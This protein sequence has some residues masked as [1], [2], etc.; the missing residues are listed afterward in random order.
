MSD[1]QAVNGFV[2]VDESCKAQGPRGQQQ[3]AIV[4][5]KWKNNVSYKLYPNVIYYVDCA[6]HLDGSRGCSTGRNQ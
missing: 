6:V 5:W 1:R 4:A 2:D 3:I